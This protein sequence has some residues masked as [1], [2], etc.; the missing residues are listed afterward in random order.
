MSSPLVESLVDL[1]VDRAE[2]KF[3]KSNRKCNQTITFRPTGGIVFIVVFFGVLV[4]A[5]LYLLFLGDFN[6]SE[7]FPAL[8]KVIALIAFFVYCIISSL[9]DLSDRVVVDKE[10]L[11]VVGAWRPL[12]DPTFVEKVLWEFK[13]AYPHGDLEVELAWKDIKSVDYEWRI[14]TI[15][16][17]SGEVFKF[18]ANNYD[19]KVVGAIKRYWRRHGRTI[20]SR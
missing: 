11:L 10:K 16:T 5:I 9:R 18:S 15:T 14:V 13:H 2:K 8:L 17:R 1:F 20:N 4:L 6:V 19:Y 7:D 12:Q 3:A